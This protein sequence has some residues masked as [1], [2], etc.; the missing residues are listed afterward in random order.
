[1]ILIDEAIKSTLNA[2]I[3]TFV[4]VTLVAFIGNYFASQRN[5]NSELCYLLFYH[6]TQMLV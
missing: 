5:I 4:V 6:M 3:A 1:M 2:E